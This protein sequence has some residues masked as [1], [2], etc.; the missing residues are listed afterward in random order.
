MTPKKKIKDYINKSVRRLKHRKGYGVHSPFAFSVITDVIEERLPYYAYQVMNRVYLK[1]SPITS[2]VAFLLFRL[3]NRFR[4]RKILELNCDGGY[5]LLPFVLVD[6]R[7][8]IISIGE[9]FEQKSA[10]NRL[11][12]LDKRA[13]QVS[14]LRNAAEI[15]E[16]YKADFIV[17]TSFPK[18]F[19]EESLF[20]FIKS[21]MHEN[22]VVFVKGIQDKR[23][24]ENF[25]DSLCDDEEI[26]ITMDLY[27]YGLAIRKPRFFKQHYIVSF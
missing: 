14:Y 19:T 2:K 16:D 5:T 24:F 8:E 9:E 26:A 17:L 11:A 10:I 6:S 22:T 20:S 3:A 13:N 27:D 4:S 21:H 15:D 25:W 1:N 23:P 18:G 7:N 12:W